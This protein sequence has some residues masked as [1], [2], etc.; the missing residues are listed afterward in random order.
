MA[1]VKDQGLV[2][3]EDDDWAVAEGEPDVRGWRV[4]TADDKKMGEVK[5]LLA[6]PTATS[7]RYIT[8]DLDSE[9]AT[10]Q[11]ENTIRIP[12]PVRASTRPIEQSSWTSQRVT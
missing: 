7:V 5:D 12:S 9:V 6:D 11:G 3:L 8:V 4:V 1:D 10:A 2:S